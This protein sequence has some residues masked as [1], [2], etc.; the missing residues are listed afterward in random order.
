[1]KNVFQGK[2]IVAVMDSLNSATPVKLG[3]KSSEEVASDYFWSALI[4]SSS[5]S[6]RVC[7]DCFYYLYLRGSSWKLSLIGPTEWGRIGFGEY[8]GRCLLRQ[9]MTWSVELADELKRGSA[10]NVALMQYLDGIREQL[11][12]TGG[13]SNLLS[14]GQQFLPY[15]QRVLSTALGCSLRH[16]VSLHD[17][18]ELS[19][20]KCLE[21]VFNRL[22]LGFENGTGTFSG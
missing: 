21:S 22:A 3:Y 6:F 1:M 20:E 17:Q 14:E 11:A 12:E 19:P 7:C 2:G 9:D 13:W 15:Q 10:V 4:L 16:S 18:R 8:A 5:F